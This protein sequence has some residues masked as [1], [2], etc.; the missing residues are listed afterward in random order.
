MKESES[1]E[2][3]TVANLVSGSRLVFIPFIIYFLIKNLRL[4]ALIFIMISYLTDLI[5][6]YLA[7][8]LNQIS[9]YGKIIDPVTD[10]LNLAAILI[11]LYFT[12]AF[13]LWCLIIVLLRD[14][15]ILAGSLFLIKYQESVLPS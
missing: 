2:F 15:L 12:D 9:F 4:W 1:K 10:K 8:R 14:I 7:R 3:F 6:G 13:P 5:D 11:T